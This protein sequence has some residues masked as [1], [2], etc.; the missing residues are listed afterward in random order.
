MH[1]PNSQILLA[2]MPVKFTADGRPVKVQAQF[3]LRFLPK[4]S[5]VIELKDLPANTKIEFESTLIVSL[6]NGNEI[7][8]SCVS[9]N[10]QSS[11]SGST[12]KCVL[13]PT[14]GNCTLLH[15]NDRL[16]SVAFDILNFPMFFKGQ[17][18]VLEAIDDKGKSLRLLGAVKLEIHPWMIEICAVPESEETKKKLQNEGGYAVTHTGIVVRSDGRTFSVEDVE[19]L[20]THTL[21][22]FLS[23]A[24]GSF[25]GIVDLRGRDRTGESTWRLVGSPIV[26]PWSK[27]RQSWFD[28]MH[29]HVLTEVF[30]GFCARLNNSNMGEK[31]ERGLHW[32]L[33]GNLGT[34]FSDA[35]TVLVQAALEYLAHVQLQNG[36]RRRS[37]SE[38]IKNALV[39]MEIC[40]EIPVSCQ[41]LKAFADK[42][43]LDH[44]PHVLTELRNDTVHVRQKYGEVSSG[45]HF[46]AKNLGLWYVEMMLLRFFNYSGVYS[47]RLVPRW[48]GEVESVPW[49]KD[50]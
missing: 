42:H 34:D 30:G 46:Q 28:T 19:D 1:E 45:V 29:G 48:V 35:D 31:F 17:D 21:R 2:E 3:V 36:K 4:P 50:K 33:L 47:N 15:T 32:Y 13:V 5:L 22:M 27:G 7:E 49:S 26:D 14:G 18:R 6:E 23:F 39:E 40:I 25:C 16:Q 9:W 37:A 44:G 12:S 41:K 38:T 43:R 10:T 11:D 8:V 24:S 20:I